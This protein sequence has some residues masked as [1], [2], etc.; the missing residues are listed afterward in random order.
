MVFALGQ[1]QLAQLQPQPVCVGYVVACLG[2]FLN[3]LDDCQ[4]LKRLLQVNGL[5]AVAQLQA[6]GGLQCCVAHQVLGKGHQVA[7]VPIGSVELHHGEFG[8][9]PYRNA[10]VA[11]VAVDFEHA[12]EAAHDQAL[13][14]QLGRDA[15]K[16]LLIQRVVVR[17]EG[18]RIGPTRDRVQHGCFDFQKSVRD[19]EIA[20][21]A[22]GFAA[23]HKAAAGALVGHQI[24]VALAVLDFLVM[25]AV[26]LVRH[27]SQAFG[28]QAHDGGVD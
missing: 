1:P 20:Q 19:H 10:F 9:V 28:Q 5:T 2:V 16:H 4:A 8:V 26:E 23:G 21:G 25:H 3:R 18:P 14:V 15:Q 13:Q 27:G 17:G 11:E 7:V 24:D 22:D 6:A 12:L